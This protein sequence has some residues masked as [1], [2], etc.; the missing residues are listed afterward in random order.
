MRTLL[1]ALLFATVSC[2]KLEDALAVPLSIAQELDLIIPLSAPSGFVGET[3]ISTANDDRFKPYL[4]KIKDYEIKSIVYEVVSPE[5][6]GTTLANGTMS[7]GSVTVNVTNFDLSKL[8]VNT[9]QLSSQEFSKI[10]EDFKNG[11]D[12]L[13]KFSGSVDRKPVNAKIKLT[14]NIELRVI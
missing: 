6:A 1:I 3:L 10:G 4:S 2:E 9:L 13:F 8:S 7:F 11:N 14:F 5:P 12:I